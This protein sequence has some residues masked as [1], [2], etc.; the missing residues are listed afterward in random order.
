MPRT[1]APGLLEED[2]VEEVVVVE[3][4]EAEAEAEADV[5]VVVDK[6][7]EEVEVVEEEAAESTTSLVASARIASRTSTRDRDWARQ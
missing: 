6:V 4:A 7:V 5:V 3:G 1:H 2:E